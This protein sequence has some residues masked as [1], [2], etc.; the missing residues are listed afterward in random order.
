[1]K[2]QIVA[3]AIPFLLIF[4]IFFNAFFLVNGGAE[5]RDG[6]RRGERLREA[7]EAAAKLARILI[8]DYRAKEVWLFGSL[9]RGRSFHRLS[10]RHSH[11]VN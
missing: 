10:Q 11:I 3:Y 4:S 7:R 5:K 1:M 2:K 6:K 9:A 8:Q